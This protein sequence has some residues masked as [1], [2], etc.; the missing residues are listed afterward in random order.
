MNNTKSI[1]NG[2]IKNH[3]QLFFDLCEVL[4]NEVKNLRLRVQQLKHELTKE[5]NQKITE[6]RARIAELEEYTERSKIFHRLLEEERNNTKKYK[7]ALEKI[8]IRS[9]TSQNLD[10]GFFDMTAI[11]KNALKLEK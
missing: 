8:L 4:L 5:K 3:T 2:E 10:D 11:A 6:K 7:E 9:D 1:D